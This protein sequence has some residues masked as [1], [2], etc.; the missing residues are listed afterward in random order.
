[1]YLLIKYIKSVLWRVAKC[2]Y[3]IEEARCLKVN[4]Q[5]RL[6]FLGMF[7]YV[8]FYNRS[9]IHAVFRVYT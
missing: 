4:I 3:Y 9:A 1:M 6:N 8:T 5:K 7:D 2:L